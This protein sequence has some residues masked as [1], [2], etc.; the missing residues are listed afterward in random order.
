MGL[1]YIRSAWGLPK[2]GSLVAQFHGHLCMPGKHRGREARRIAM[3]HMYLGRP[4]ST[5]MMNSSD[6]GC[7]TSIAIYIADVLIALMHL[8]C[9]LS[10]MHQGCNQALALHLSIQGGAC[11]G[12]GIACTTGMRNM[13]RRAVHAG[14]SSI[15]GNAERHQTH[16]FLCYIYSTGP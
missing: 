16:L 5:V 8:C 11:I 2:N 14:A 15:A 13:C 12:G 4:R 9:P 6:Q 10:L 7:S 1:V 3:P